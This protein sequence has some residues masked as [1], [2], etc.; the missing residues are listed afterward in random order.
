M[1]SRKK[2][3]LAIFVISELARGVKGV[4]SGK[5]S[6]R[7]RSREDFTGFDHRKEA[8]QGAAGRLQSL[9]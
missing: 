6:G 2:K 7:G 3:I 4:G 1:E 9:G 8:L 5:R